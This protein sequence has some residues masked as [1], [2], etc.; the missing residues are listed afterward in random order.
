MPYAIPTVDQF[1]A[2]FP[3]DFPFAVSPEPTPPPDGGD[4]TD[5]TKVRDEDITNAINL[6]QFNVNQGLFSTQANFQQ[7]FLYLAAHYLVQMLLA[8]TEGLAS[9]YN[10][11]TNSKG[12]GDVSESFVIPERVKASP[13]LSSLSVTRYG[14]IYLSIVTP[15]LIGNVMT[16][17]RMSLP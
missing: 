15:L 16:F 13:F 3:R 17:H 9:K 10:W 5:L 14:S 7:A 12:V 1:K 4:Q 11:L 2:G 8:S 6:A